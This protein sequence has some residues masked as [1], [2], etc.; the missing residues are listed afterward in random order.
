MPEFKIDSFAGGRNTDDDPLVIGS[1][2][3]V[4]G[5]MNVWAPRGALTKT[6]GTT[7]FATFTASA[8]TTIRPRFLAY[9][10]SVTTAYNLYYRMSNL[11]SSGGSDFGD[12]TFPFA[13]LNATE[14]LTPI[15]YS[16]GTIS[17]S[18]ATL[19]SATGSGT[20][21]LTHVV[22]GDRFRVDATADK[23]YPVASV[24]DDTHLTLDGVV[25]AAVATGSAYLIQL[26]FLTNRDPAHAVL[27]GQMMMSTTGD[28]MQQFNGSGFLRLSAGPKAAFLA[29][30]KNYMFAA[31]TSTAESRLYWSAIKDPTSWPT[32]NFIDIDKDKGKISG[33][34]AF[35]NDLIVFKTFGM[36]RVLGE[37]FDPS[38]PTYSVTPIAVPADFIF[39]GHKTCAVWKGQLVFC[40]QGNLYAYSP[41]GDRIT[42]L[43][44]KFAIDIKRKWGDPN[45]YYDENARLYA[46]SL[47]DH[48][49]LKPLNTDGVNCG[50][51][52]D[53]GAWWLADNDF[54]TANDEFQNSPMVVFPNTGTDDAIATRL[55]VPSED[56]AYIAAW[57]LFPVGQSYE[58]QYVGPLVSSTTRPIQAVWISREFNIGFGT[59]K[60]LTAYIAKQSAGTI[61]IDWRVDQ[62]SYVTNSVDMTVG[63]GNL[64]R[65]VLRINQ[66][67]S[68]IQFKISQSTVDQTFKLFG[69]VCS[70][71]EGM[72]DNKR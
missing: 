27:N 14:S 3:C 21:W 19:N 1:D 30:Y 34:F 6:P 51:L 48:Y 59:F 32:N 52:T 54:D 70:Y 60:T 42:L 22:S 62:G 35:G 7:L 31:R 53:T 8:D 43:S 33:L 38:N 49:F 58:D 23:W 16:T 28:T 4:N 46:V 67:G 37:V 26:K 63:R 44:K 36:Y 41:G 61:S 40:A 39:N 18:G 57:D 20:S 25:P 13:S 71:D 72:A 45:D 5:S 50:I 24:E 64:I 55:L 11:A 15:G 56:R 47:R 2:Q 66:T 10:P 68:T 17:I 9:E 69:L 12:A 65:V 29:I